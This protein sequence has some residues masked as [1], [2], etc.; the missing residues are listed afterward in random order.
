MKRLS[1]VRSDGSQD[2][3][4]RRIPLMATR[5]GVVLV[6]FVS[7]S[8]VGCGKKGTADPKSAEDEKTASAD[9]APPEQGLTP[10]EP[11]AAPQEVVVRMRV[12]NPGALADGALEATSLSIGVGS[13]GIN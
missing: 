11:V 8:S 3:M 5:A 13:G 2:A 6:A 7:I 1:S 4:V 9:S 10:L 12:N